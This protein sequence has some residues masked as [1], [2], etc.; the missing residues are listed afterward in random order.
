MECY[1]APWP[2]LEVIPM[3]TDFEGNGAVEVARDA[4]AQSLLGRIPSC[5]VAAPK[6]QI[7]TRV[8]QYIF[9]GYRLGL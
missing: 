3:D 9:S 6:K 4:M 5:S 2:W 1:G 8:L 7:S